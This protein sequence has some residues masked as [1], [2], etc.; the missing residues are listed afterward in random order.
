MPSRVDAIQKRHELGPVVT[1][2]HERDNRAKVRHKVRVSDLSREALVELPS[3]T[4]FLVR[5]SSARWLVW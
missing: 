5:W 2:L 3:R 4:P 1:Q